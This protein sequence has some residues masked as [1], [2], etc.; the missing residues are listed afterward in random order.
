MNAKR[1]NLTAQQ[2]YCTSRLENTHFGVGS[3]LK[4]EK[5]RLLHDDITNN[6]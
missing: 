5:D 3:Q 4:D 6:V 2:S 1:N